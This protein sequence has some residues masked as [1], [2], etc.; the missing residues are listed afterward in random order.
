MHVSSVAIKQQYVIAL[1]DTYLHTLETNR[2]AAFIVM[3]VCLDLVI[4]SVTLG[5]YIQSLLLN[6]INVVI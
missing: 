3:L 4:Y 5:L 6:V 2:T 1:T